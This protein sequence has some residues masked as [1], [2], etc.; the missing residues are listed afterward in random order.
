MEKKSLS[1]TRTTIL[2]LLETTL[3]YNRVESDIHLPTQAGLKKRKQGVRSASQVVF[4]IVLL[5]MFVR[6]LSKDGLAQ[7]LFKRVSCGT[8]DIDCCM[9]YCGTITSKIDPNG[10]AALH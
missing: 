6:H 1:M 9:I 2:R 7:Q 5:E 8:M 3:V 4:G 10:D